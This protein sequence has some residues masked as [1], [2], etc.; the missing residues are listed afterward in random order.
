MTISTMDQLVS[1]IASSQKLAFYT[2]SFT[3]VAGSFYAVNMV[4]PSSF[5]TLSLPANASA[6]G[7]TYSQ[8]SPPAAGTLGWN[9]ATGGNT[10]YLSRVALLSTTA[11]NLFLYDLLWSCS[12]LSTAN[13]SQTVSWGSGSGLPSRAGSPGVAAELWVFPS[14]NWPASAITLTAHYTNQSGVSGQL[15]TATFSSGST[16]W[17]AVQFVLQSGDT[18][19]QSIQSV[20][21]NATAGSTNYVLLLM[22]RVVSVFMQ[23]PNVGVLL[24]FAGV[25]LPVVSDAAVLLAIAQAGAATSGNI[26]GQIDIAQG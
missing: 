6:G 10:S 14:A 5:G 21:Q 1:A 12:G 24:D 17:R 26:L 3:T 8:S 22:N 4:T 15:A 11:V 13:S 7:T 19:I 2:P 16:A 20:T 25:G 9:A 18:G 23:T